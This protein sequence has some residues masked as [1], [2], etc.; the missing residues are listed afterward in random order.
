MSSTIRAPPWTRGSGSKLVRIMDSERI[1]DMPNSKLALPRKS[2]TLLGTL[3]LMVAL[4][5]CLSVGGANAAGPGPTYVYQDI[6]VDTTWDEAGSPYIVNASFAISEGVTLTIGPNVTVQVDPGLIIT[7]NGALV[8]DG[9]DGQINFTQNQTGSANMWGGVT[10]TYTSEG[11]M[12]DHVRFDNATQAVRVTNCT[13]PISNCLFLDGLNSAIVY[14]MTDSAAITVTGCTF[15][16]EITNAIYISQSVSTTGTEIKTIDC[17]VDISNNMFS[18]DGRA[19]YLYRYANAVG[20]SNATING[21][22]IIESNNINNTDGNWNAIYVD[23]AQYA[24]DEANSTII[25]DFIVSDNDLVQTCYTFLYVS[26]YIYSYNENST[27]TYDGDFVVGDNTI[28]NPTGPI[29]S[30]YVDL[31]AYGYSGIVLNSDITVT[32]NDVV[33]CCSDGDFFVEM[34]SDIEAYDHSTVDVMRNI[35][36]SGN[37]VGQ[38]Y[39]FVDIEYNGVDAVDYA[40]ISIIGDVEVSGNVVDDATVDA[41]IFELDAGAAEESSVHIDAPLLFKDNQIN[42]TANSGDAALK[43]YRQATASGDA[44]CTINAEMCIQNNELDAHYNGIIYLYDSVSANDDSTAEITGSVTVSSNT[45]TIE[46]DGLITTYPTAGVT[47][48]RALDVGVNGTVVLRSDVTVQSND[49]IGGAYG[50]YMDVETGVIDYDYLE[51]TTIEYTGNLLV[52]NGN[53][54]THLG[55]GVYYEIDLESDWYGEVS[56]DAAVTIRDNTVDGDNGESLAR[57][58]IEVYASGHGIANL[59][60]DITIENN[61]VEGLNDWA[62]DL[63]LQ[64]L[65]QDFSEISLSG[66]YSITSNTLNECYGLLDF[67]AYDHYWVGAYFRGEDESTVT[68]DNPLNVQRNTCTNVTYGIQ[69]DRETAVYD[70]AVATVAEPICVQYNVFRNVTRSGIDVGSYFWAE[71]YGNTTIDASGD[72]V[73]AYNELY[74]SDEADSYLTGIYADMEAEAYAEVAT[75]VAWVKLTGGIVVT[76]N[77]IVMYNGGEAIDVYVYYYAD[78]EAE[79]STATVVAMSVLIADNVITGTA[80]NSADIIY[81]DPDLECSAEDGGVASVTMGTMTIEGNV[82]DVAGSDVIG[83]YLYGDYFYAEATDGSTAT[84]VSGELSVRNNEI[85]I[86]GSYAYGI[87]VDLAHYVYASVYNAV[88]ATAQMIGGITI[89]DNEIVLTGQNAIGVNIYND[90]ETYVYARG[91]DGTACLQR[92]LSVSSNKITVMG[93]HASGI[94]LEEYSAT[95]YYFEAHATFKTSFTFYDNTIVMGGED[96]YGIYASIEG[97]EEDSDSD[98]GV[99]VLEALLL[100]K[101]NRITGPEYG[102]YLDKVQ[103]LAGA[104]VVLNQVSECD[105]GIYID[106]SVAVVEQNTV[107]KCYTGLYADEC[108]MLVIE[109]NTFFQNIEY[110]A[111]IYECVESIV[112]G[113]NTFNQNWDYGL[114]ITRSSGVV[115]YNGVYTDNSYYGLYATGSDLIAPGVTA[116]PVTSVEWIINAE[117]VVRNNDV[118]FVGTLWILGGGVLT[119]DSVY[120][121][122][123]DYTAI[124]GMYSEYPL[125][126]VCEGGKLVAYDTGF[127]TDERW[128]F[129]VYGC[130]ELTDCYIENVVELYLGPT[131]QAKLTTTTIEDTDRNGIRIDDCSPVISGCIIRSAEMDGIYIQGA[132]AKPVIKDC[133]IMNNERGIYAVNTCLDKVIDNIFLENYR[134]GIYAEGVTGAIHDNIF[135][136]NWRDIYLVNSTVSVEDNEIGYARALNGQ[137]PYSSLMFQAVMDAFNIDSSQGRFE[138]LLYDYTSLDSLV[139]NFMYQNYGTGLYIVNSDV[140]ASGNEYGSLQ[141]AVYAIDSTLVFKDTVKTNFFTLSWFGDNGTKYTYDL[142]F[143]VYDGIFATGSTVT[144]EDAS[145][146]CVDDALFLEAS[147]AMISGTTFLAGDFDVYLMEGTEA[148]IYNCSYDKVK[149]EDVSVLFINSLLTV[150]VKDQ[151]GGVI[152][153]ATVTITDSTGRVW[154][155][156]VTDSKGQFKVSLPSYGMLADGKT[157]DTVNPYTVTATKDDS[158]KDVQISMGQTDGTATLALQVKKNSFFGLDPVILGAIALIV[159]VALLGA[160]LL[161]R[162]KK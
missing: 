117:C 48:E 106:E 87:E 35:A 108:N 12:L 31:E 65:A 40:A 153:G 149:I 32:G 157:N 121:Y 95:L 84:L 51:N 30:N 36:V 26:Q 137:S 133:L 91:A 99:G 124:N 57:I 81:F 159:V 56:C 79:A 100:I 150:T 96:T 112:I 9:S 7:V 13:V 78:A 143:T 101:E 123:G 162:R 20:S 120:F 86:E 70:E 147:T 126:R 74:Y 63:N 71:G 142:P 114:Y 158:S 111:Y 85:S 42:C 160:L 14:T 29:F 54:F 107:T 47:V 144:V 46:N 25:G 34:Y 66:T 122:I 151:D 45:L 139:E 148:Q 33:A 134:A 88:K 128:L 77:I 69:I 92:D 37:I 27:A 141:Y 28:A 136:F 127:Y 115:I 5:A 131:S 72:M 43:I 89:V 17:P 76:N 135:L 90:A 161:A 50:V 55:T 93:D 154:A 19:V 1:N 58:Y 94:Y 130:L 38:A 4:M 68:V 24:Y 138:N 152:E 140:K 59:C 49:F 39:G 145:I 10:F 18:G 60:G 11:S 15:N 102:I 21:D 41:L 61:I 82:I 23:L 75:A 16:Y 64:L 8:A 113:N 6:T 52:S 53:S 118:Y 73:I 83:I 125:L 105:T 3:A 156:G 110:G 116:M 109:G 80:V 129:E 67:E 98:Y 2:L 155:T 44:E 146:E 62:V 104:E 22:I 97:L 132:N 103:E 119:L